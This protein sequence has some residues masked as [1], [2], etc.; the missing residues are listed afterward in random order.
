MYSVPA[1]LLENFSGTSHFEKVW[2][3]TIAREI[4]G[5]M[6][7]LLGRDT[8]VIITGEDVTKAFLDAARKRVDQEVQHAVEDD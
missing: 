2:V 3:S 4:Y 7:K 8:K 1:G 6:R 5:E